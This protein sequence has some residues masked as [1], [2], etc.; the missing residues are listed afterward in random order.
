MTVNREKL[1]LGGV[2]VVAAILC[3]VALAC[4][5]TAAPQSAS[6][7]AT[8]AAEKAE[9][10]PEVLAWA[11]DTDCATCHMTELES[12]ESEKAPM[13]AHAAFDLACVTCN[14]DEA[15]PEIHADVDASSKLPSRAKKTVL[16]PELSCLTCHN[17]EQLAEATVDSEVL[18]DV[19]GLVVNPHDLPVNDDH[20]TITCASCHK[21]HGEKP[22]NRTA[23]ATCNSC[24]HASVFACGT[25]HEH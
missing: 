15:L 13:G 21:M 17:A 19:E 16:D 20:A 1:I 6:D 9:V 18:T 12:A 23:M 3:F 8:P 11:E 5:A 25:C 22:I 14:T 4:N 2:A 7:D 10:S 24:H